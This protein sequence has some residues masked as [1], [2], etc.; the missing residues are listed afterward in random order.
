LSRS[1][2]EVRGKV[3]ADSLYCIAA[4]VSLSVKPRDEKPVIVMPFQGL[5]VALATY[6]FESAGRNPGS[7][8]FFILQHSHSDTVPEANL[9]Q[10]RLTKLN[11]YAV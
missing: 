2:F 9:F 8:S 11:L 1:H 6:R 4:S 10:E 7:V 3:N 5:C